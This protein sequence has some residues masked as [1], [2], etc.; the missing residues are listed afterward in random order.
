MRA[1]SLK[2]PES[3]LEASG[4]C[5]EALALTRAE[6]VRMAIENMN[7]RVQAELRATRLAEASHRVREE[8][9]RINAEFAEIE[10]DPDA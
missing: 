10:R 3:L 8:G 7:R 1:I 2:L 9:Q 6:Y 4:M 5:A